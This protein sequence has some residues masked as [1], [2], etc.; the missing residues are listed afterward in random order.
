MK[1]NKI[2]LSA[3]LLIFS[4]S[5]FT[6]CKKK[7]EETEIP[8]ATTASAPSY[9]FTNA[10]ASGAFVGVKTVT[11]QTL[12][13]V[14]L[15]PIE[16]N[17][18][19]GGFFTTAGA[20]SYVNGG[21]VTCESKSLTVQ[22]N[23]AYLFSPSATETIDFSGGTDWTIAGNSGN[24][25]PAFNYSTGSSIPTYSGIVNSSIPTTVTRAS[26][27]TIALGS[28][29]VSGSPDSIFVTV[30]S[31]AGSV[32]KLVAGNASNCVF[33]AAELASLDASSGETGLLQVAP[34]KYYSTTQS[35]KKYYFIDE[36]AYS[37]FVTVN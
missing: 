8:L 12:P 5:L 24:S 17:T 19:V 25:I 20:T 14:G 2:I 4:A 22:T 13:V 21:A 18:A 3:A 35:G 16:I 15:L 11:Y 36:A 34:L 10:S 33:S 6:S 26:G 7:A 31:G 32:Q 23:G 29:N 1:A 9:N 30:S 28:A 37:K 27:L